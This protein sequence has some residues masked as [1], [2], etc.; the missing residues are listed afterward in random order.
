MLVK[1]SNSC[2]LP[3]MFL[4]S[5]IEIAIIPTTYNN[6]RIN[7]RYAGI[8]YSV[9]FKDGI[10]AS[11]ININTITIIGISLILGYSIS[12]TINI[13][14]TIITTNSSM[15]LYEDSINAA[16]INA[17]TGIGNPM[18]VVVGASVN[19]LMVLYLLNLNIPQM[20]MR[21][22]AIKTYN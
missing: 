7:R 4:L 22:D 20:T 12:V 21:A 19:A 13:D 17:V 15:T 11:I 16:S 9:A 6:P 14:N 5:Y 10:A 3:L 18:N 1:S 8:L 2:N